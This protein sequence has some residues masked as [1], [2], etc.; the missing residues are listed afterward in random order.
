MNVKKN[1]R[2]V[3]W[4]IF[5][6][7][8]LL[9]TGVKG[10]V[11]PCWLIIYLSVLFL[12]IHY[13]LLFTTRSAVLSQSQ[14]TRWKHFI[15]MSCY[16]CWEVIISRLV[17]F[18]SNSFIFMVG[19]AFVSHCLSLNGVCCENNKCIRFC[20]TF[21]ALSHC[22]VWHF[23]CTEFKAL[24]MA[25]ISKK[26]FAYYKYWDPKMGK[27]YLTQRVFDD[28]IDILRQPKNIEDVY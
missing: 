17:F 20:Q 25:L 19:R 12:Y 22:N 7:F 26:G 21:R 27:K 1:V 11:E 8:N 9:T 10:T 16:L 18:I 5:I 28:T 4:Y 24:K 15:A 2:N 13:Y 23:Q 3:L 6:I 14:G